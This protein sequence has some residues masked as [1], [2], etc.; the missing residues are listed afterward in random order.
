MMRGAHKQNRGQSSNLS[1]K[2]IMEVPHDSSSTSANSFEKS[3]EKIENKILD[4][5]DQ[6]S[7]SD[8]SE[9]ILTE[10]EK[11]CQ[12]LDGWDYEPTIAQIEKD[13]ISAIHFNYL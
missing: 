1:D 9:R 13:D 3:I 8:R 6:L 4:R 7:T 10:L 5:I 12:D 11:T 2:K